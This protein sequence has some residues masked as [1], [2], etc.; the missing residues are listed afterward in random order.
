MFLKK[1]AS[2]GMVIIIFISLNIK[3]LFWKQVYKNFQKETDAPE[4][5]CHSK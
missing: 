2:E 4:K 5:N 3:M 1:T